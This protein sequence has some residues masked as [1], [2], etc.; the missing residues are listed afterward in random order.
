MGQI[1]WPFA[2]REEYRR[3]KFEKRIVKIT[4]LRRPEVTGCWKRCV[5][6]IKSSSITYHE[7]TEE[8]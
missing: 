3:V 2:L 7:G 1:S 8:E 4:G 6:R 5:M